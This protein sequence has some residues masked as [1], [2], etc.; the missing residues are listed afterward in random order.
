MWPPRACGW[1]EPEPVFSFLVRENQSQTAPKDGATQGRRRNGA[2]SLI[3]GMLG[4]GGLIG[5]D[6][7]HE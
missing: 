2:G 3:G 1:L 4:A 6:G 7:R 5:T